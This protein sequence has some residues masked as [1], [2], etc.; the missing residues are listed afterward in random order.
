VQ[1]QPR[2]AAEIIQLS[3]TSFLHSQGH[4]TGSTAVRQKHEGS[5][6]HRNILFPNTFIML[7]F[8]Y[9]KLTNI[10]KTYDRQYLSWDKKP[11]TSKYAKLVSTTVPLTS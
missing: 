10:T 1:N 7:K 3:K 9:L 4:S 6:A 5:H 11:V 2:Q 8:A